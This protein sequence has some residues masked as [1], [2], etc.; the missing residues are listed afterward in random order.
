M[1]ETHV[2]RILTAII[3][4][5]A[6]FFATTSCNN[7]KH[8]EAN[9]LLD[10]AYKQ[11]D[12]DRLMLLA[13]S[14]HSAG[15]ISDAKMYYWQGYAY[16]RKKDSP[17]ASS[18]WRKAMAAAISS[19]SA[20]DEVMYEKA[21]TRLSNLLCVSGDYAGTLEVSLPAI[22]RIEEL[23][24]DT[25]SD[26]VNLLIYTGLCQT[27]VGK[28]E[29]DTENAFFIANK[30]HLENIQRNRCD[31]TYKEAIAGL[32]NIAYYCVNAKKYEAALYYTGSFG[33]LLA[34]YQHRPGVDTVYIDRQIGRF[35]AY[36]AQALYMVGRRREAA[37]TYNAFLETHFCHS[38]EGQKLAETYQSITGQ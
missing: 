29:H 11:K 1:K 16:D 28:P 9:R 35:T 22:K 26:Y 3:T 27:T 12:Y 14:L 8:E 15:D 34:E 31:A 33:E 25:T 10:T 6:T 18:S 4:V 37:D 21:A 5:A 36:K 19:G 2:L 20:D 32:V 7:A 13:D 17:N 24:R 23:K 30:K 38:A